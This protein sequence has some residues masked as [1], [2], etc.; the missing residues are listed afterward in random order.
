[1]FRPQ[2]NWIAFD[3]INIQSIKQARDSFAAYFYALL[4]LGA[5][6]QT[7]GGVYI[8]NLGSLNLLCPQLNTDLWSVFHW[9]S[10]GKA[11]S[12]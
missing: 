9:G 2:Y 12:I 8:R 1:M 5:S 3:L 4:I 6:P 11:P 10:G 7:P